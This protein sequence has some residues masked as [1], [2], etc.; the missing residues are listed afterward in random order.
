[1][2]SS[3]WNALYCFAYTFFYSSIAS[4][5]PFGQELSSC[6]FNLPNVPGKR[7][8]WIFRRQPVLPR[9]APVRQPARSLWRRLCGTATQ[10]DVPP[11]KKPSCVARWRRVLPADRSA[12][13]AGAPWKLLQNK[14][15]RRK[16]RT[17]Q[18]CP[19]CFSPPPFTSRSC[20]S[21]RTKL[22][23]DLP[24]DFRGA[25]VSL[26]RLQHRKRGGKWDKQTLA[27]P[28]TVFSISKVTM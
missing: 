15:A 27:L 6:Y 5:N 8:S 24:R 13:K 19:E 14:G 1:M 4:S 18:E 9:D 25:R 17:G 28:R 20:G 23:G 2:R 16:G 10:R 3:A 7:L 11:R 22:N 26:P 21:H 12:D